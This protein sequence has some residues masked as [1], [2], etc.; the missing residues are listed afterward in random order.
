MPRSAS[1]WSFNVAV[2]LLRA[3]GDAERVYGGYDEEAARFLSTAPERSRDLVLKC[4]S[5]DAVGRALTRAGVAKVI[6]TWRN[7]TDAIASF[8]QMFEV[9]FEH[10]FAVTRDSLLLYDFHRKTGNAIALHYDEIAREPF[11]S[12]R[13]ID[14]YLALDSAAEVMRAVCERTS[15]AQMREK[16]NELAGTSNQARLIKLEK[17]TYDPET[18]LNL[19]HIRN[20]GSGYGRG[21]LTPSQ[22]TRAVELARE[23][24]VRD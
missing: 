8:M 3:R 19:N 4:H 15:F 18:L 22:V 23:F 24:G 11:E 6:Y 20:G 10:A 13:R 1:T 14:T 9:D 5:L 17:T 12:V 7:I 2:G 16:A 21:I